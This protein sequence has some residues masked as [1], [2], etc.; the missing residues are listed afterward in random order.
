M[1]K[2]EKSSKGENALITE[3]KAPKEKIVPIRETSTRGT[4]VRRVRPDGT[5]VGT[6]TLLITGAFVSGAAH[7]PDSVKYI[8]VRT[9]NEKGEISTELPL[10][11]DPNLTVVKIGFIDFMDPKNKKFFKPLGNDF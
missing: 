7:N 5:F 8:S 1:E 4:I 10:Q 9:L 6:D 11:Y 3:E 2:I